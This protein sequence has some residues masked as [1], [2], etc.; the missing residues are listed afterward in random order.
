MALA[1]MTRKGSANVSFQVCT[2]ILLKVDSRVILSLSDV[3]PMVK[4]AKFST[5]SDQTIELLI[6]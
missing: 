3:L 6:D 2:T 1:S 5:K 4:T